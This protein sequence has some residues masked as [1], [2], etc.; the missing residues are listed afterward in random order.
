VFARMAAR[1]LPPAKA[2][3]DGDLTVQGDFSTAE[4]LGEMFGEASPW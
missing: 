3:L 2:L 1:E 4:K